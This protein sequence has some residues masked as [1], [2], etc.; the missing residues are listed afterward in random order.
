MSKT[1]VE[2]RKVLARGEFLQHQNKHNAERNFCN[3]CSTQ[4]LVRVEIIEFQNNLST[5]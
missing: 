3:L 2:H 5:Q 1:K 4:M